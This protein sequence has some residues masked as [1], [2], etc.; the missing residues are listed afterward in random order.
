MCSRVFE[1]PTIDIVFLNI[2]LH[3]EH[4][5]SGTTRLS[6]KVP[7]PLS[8]Q[9]NTGCLQRSPLKCRMVF[10]IQVNGNPLLT[11]ISMALQLFYGFFYSR[12]F[13]GFSDSYGLFQLSSCFLGFSWIFYNSY[14]TFQCEFTP[15]TS[16][17]EPDFAKKAIHQDKDLDANKSIEEFR[18]FT[19]RG[20]KKQVYHMYNCMYIMYI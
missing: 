5:L 9:K 16:A 7:D 14:S 13:L 19:L 3:N 12:C 11:H 15:T 18:D 6:C 17:H 4:G 20:H 1:L 2:F 10:I 8:L